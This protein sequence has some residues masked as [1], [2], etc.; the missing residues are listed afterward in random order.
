VRSSIPPHQSSVRL[1]E[2]GS[3]GKRLAR[4]ATPSVL[5]APEGADGVEVESVSKS[6][7]SR[8]VIVV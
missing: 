6:N 8:I 2:D 7:R 4:F 5:P 3:A 1:E